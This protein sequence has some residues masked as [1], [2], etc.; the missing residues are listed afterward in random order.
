M[1]DTE[2]F[3]KIFIHK[4]SSTT[5]SFQRTSVIP[6]VRRNRLKDSN[7][8]NE[9]KSGPIITK[10]DKEILFINQSCNHWFLYFKTFDLY[11]LFY[12]I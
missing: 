7:I 1:H 8:Q 10:F 9:R 4:F 2:A 11:D 6:L 5:K 12:K 3:L